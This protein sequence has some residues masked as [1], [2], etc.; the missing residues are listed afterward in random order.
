MVKGP[1]LVDIQTFSKYPG[2]LFNF[3]VCFPL[4]HIIYTIVFCIIFC[5]VWV[6]FCQKA[7]NLRAFHPKKSSRM[8]K[9]M[10]VKVRQ[11]SAESA[12]SKD[13]G[14]SI[15]DGGWFSQQKMG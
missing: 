15:G 2:V 3:N 1:H 5:F 13:L 8:S 11:K 12:E 6:A 9:K 7:A 4:I 14:F 10:P